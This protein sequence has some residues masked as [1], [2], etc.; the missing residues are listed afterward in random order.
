MNTTVNPP[1]IFTLC[2]ISLIVTAMTF[3]IRAGIL[4]QLGEQFSL[5]DTELGW[6]N[7]MA[8]W[9]FPTATIFGGVLYNL[10]GAKRLIGLAFVFFRFY[11]GITN[12]GRKRTEWL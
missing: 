5:S 7:A 3:A 2:C 10:I 8:F 11:V 12:F 9:G 4:G 6:I 1:R